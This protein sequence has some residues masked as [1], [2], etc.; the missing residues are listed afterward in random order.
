MEADGMVSRTDLL[1]RQSILDVISVTWH[2]IAAITAVGVGIFGNSIV[3][4]AFGADTVIYTVSALLV[5]LRERAAQNAG[6]GLAWDQR[7]LFFILGVLYFLLALYILNEAGSRLFYRER[8]DS[9]VAGLILAIVAFLAAVAFSVLK[10]LTA[11]DLESAELLLE[12]KENS[13]RCYLPVVLF[14][15]LWLPLRQGCWWADPV[16]G[17]LMIPFILREGWKAIE[18]SKRS[19]SG[20]NFTK[21]LV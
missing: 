20:R 2:G 9:L 4:T 18:N 15:G 7:R 12:A 16:A 1:S 3:L 8:P 5:L 17:L 14:F 21:P 13:I 10:M 11:K 6:Q 19:L